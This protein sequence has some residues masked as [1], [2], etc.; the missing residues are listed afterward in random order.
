MKKEPCES[1]DDTM[2]MNI[3][4][5]QNQWDQLRQIVISLQ[6]KL[7][8]NEELLRSHKLKCDAM[9]DLITSLE[10]QLQFE[11]NL[12]KDGHFIWKI[13]QFRSKLEDI[14]GIGRQLSSEA[15]YTSRY[16]YK[17]RLE[18]HPYKDCNGRG[19][20]FALFIKLLKSEYDF[21]LQWPCQKNVK[22]RL[23]HQ[24]DRSKDSPWACDAIDSLHNPCA[25]SLFICV[26]NLE[27]YFYE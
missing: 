19:T 25:S 2:H 9:K 22:A 26:E 10:L 6:T 20:C 21:L 11:R 18:L 16:G 23:L 8:D 14:C 3:Q 12:S 27:K 24:L 1:T 15:F 5:S 7:Q 4:H 13:D 17:F